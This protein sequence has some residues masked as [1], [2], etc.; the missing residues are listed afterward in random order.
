MKIIKKALLNAGLPIIVMQLKNGLT[1]FTF[2]SVKH[3]QTRG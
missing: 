1:A 3:E 2:R